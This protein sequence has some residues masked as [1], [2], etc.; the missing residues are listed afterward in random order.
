MPILERIP[1]RKLMRGSLRVIQGTAVVSGNAG[2]VKTLWESAQGLWGLVRELEELRTKNLVGVYAGGR[3]AYRQLVPPPELEKLQQELAEE[4]RSPKEREKITQAIGELCEDYANRRGKFE[5]DFFQTVR[6][7]RA[8]CLSLAESDLAD[9]IIE[10]YNHKAEEL[11]KEFTWAQDSIK[12]LILSL[13]EQIASVDKSISEIASKNFFDRIL[14]LM[15]GQS[16]INGLALPVSKQSNFAFEIGTKPPPLLSKPEKKSAETQT[17][18]PA[19]RTDSGGQTDAPADS[20]ATTTGQ[21][22]QTDTPTDTRQRVEETVN[23]TPTENPQPVSTVE[24]G[25]SPQNTAPATTDAATQTAQGGTVPKKVDYRELPTQA[26]LSGA[27]PEAVLLKAAYET[28]QNGLKLFSTGAN[29]YK[30]VTKYDNLRESLKE[31][32]DKYDESL[33]RY[34]E[35]EQQL[36]D[37]ERVRVVLNQVSVYQSEIE[38]PVTTLKAYADALAEVR[39]DPAVYYEIFRF[40][41]DYLERLDL[42]WQ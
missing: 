13:Q 8:H 23:S 36:T 18:V 21:A 2:T 1:N 10:V 38:L 35:L 41:M 27:T 6:R 22:N 31:L 12:P 19:Q 26:N 37:L 5:D 7:M 16:T 9:R 33:K 3:G 15:P 11:Q 17:D 29:L 40:L 14:E 30:L 20:T 42:V 39:A 28:L 34:R 24:I 25:S 4:G 32:Q